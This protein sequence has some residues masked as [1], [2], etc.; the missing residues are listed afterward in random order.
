MKNDFHSRGNKF[1]KLRAG[2]R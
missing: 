1:N 2:C